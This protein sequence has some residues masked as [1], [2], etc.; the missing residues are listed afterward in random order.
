M[1]KN[2]VLIALGKNVSELR[3][4]KELTQEQLAGMKKALSARVIEN[5]F[6]CCCE[7]KSETVGAIC[8]FC[9]EPNICCHACKEWIEERAENCCRC[10]FGSHFIEGGCEF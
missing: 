5:C 4:K 2:P 8:P 7:M 1:K 9:G 3:N 6:N 10:V